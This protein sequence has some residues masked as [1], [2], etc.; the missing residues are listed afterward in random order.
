MNT[1]LPRALPQ[2]MGVSSKAILNFINAIEEK[3]LGLHSFMLLR[4]G[5]VVAEGYWKPFAPEYTHMLFS[6]SKSFTSTAIGFAVQEGLLSLHD[7]VLSFFPDKLPCAPCENMQKME[8]RHLI[9][10][11]TGHTVEPQTS[12]EDPDWVYTFLSSY[13]AEEPGSHFLYNTFATYMLSAILTSVAGQTVRDYLEPRLFAPL[14]IT[15]IWWETCP[16]GIS[17]G[18]FGLNVKTED[19]AKFSTFLLQ[20][21]QWEGRQLLNPEWIEEATAYHI[22]NYGATPDWRSGYGYQFWR[23]QI[24]GIYRGDGAFGQYCVVMPQY[25][26]TFVATSGSDDLQGILDQV[27]AYLIPGMEDP[28]EQDPEALNAKL[29]SLSMPYPTGAADSETPIRK[30]T[31]LLSDNEAGYR[32]LRYDPETGMWT[33]ITDQG[34]Y[35]LHAGYQSWQF[36]TT[37]VTASPRSSKMTLFK[38]YAAAYAWNGNT[39]DIAVYYYYSPTME[40]IRITVTDTTVDMTVTKRFNFNGGS[41]HIYGIRKNDK[42]AD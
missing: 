4:H 31:Y 5:A 6:L 9:N 18:G 36:G 29:S 37:C 21:G 7:K 34:S 8:V 40:N 15:D 33:I 3:E 1:S 2:E 26:A 27:W 11:C 22:P 41:Y 14:G 28:S 12:P 19:I 13:V 30:G 39:C 16:K 35:E 10:M 25:D 38:D 20:K 23:C 17:T 32:Q 42:H 24:P